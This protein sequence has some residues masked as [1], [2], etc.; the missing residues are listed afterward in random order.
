MALRSAVDTM[1]SNSLREDSAELTKM[2]PEMD[3]LK[4]IPVNWATIMNLLKRISI[5]PL[6]NSGFYL[7]EYSR[8]CVTQIS[9]RHHGKQLLERG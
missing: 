8:D 5:Y 9:S 7:E 1:G 4:V 3:K 2:A 6:D